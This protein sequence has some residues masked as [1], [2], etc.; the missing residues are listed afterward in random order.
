MHLVVIAYPR[1]GSHMVES[2]I[3]ADTYGGYPMMPSENRF[4]LEFADF[5]DFADLYR[6]SDIPSR[7]VLSHL[8]VV[9]ADG[10]DDDLF[11]PMDAAQRAGAKFLILGRRDPLAAWCSYQLVLSHG[12]GWMEKT[13]EGHQITVDPELAAVAIGRW[14]QNIAAAMARYPGAVYLPYEAITIDT[15]RWA[16]DRLGVDATVTEATTERVSPP[17]DQYVTNL[18]DLRAAFPV[19]APYPWE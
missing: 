2:M 10:S 1:S 19:P 9:E 3:A 13:P 7:L 11:W 14:Q 4:G 16:L 6:Q 15:V 12:R 17:L 18:A 8:K 5:G